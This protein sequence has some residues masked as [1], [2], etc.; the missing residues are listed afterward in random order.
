MSMFWIFYEKNVYECLFLMH[1]IS[2]WNKPI[3]IKKMYINITDTFGIVIILK[4]A[5]ERAMNP[6]IT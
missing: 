2:I 6:N 3:L 4:K 1:F 5:N